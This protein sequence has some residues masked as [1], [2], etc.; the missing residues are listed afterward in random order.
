MDIPVSRLN[1]R[2]ALQLPTE[3]PLGLVFVVGEISEVVHAATT[4][5]QTEIE[6][7]EMSHRLRCRLT[8]RVAAEVEIKK[9]DWIRAGGHLT[10]DPYHADYVLLARDVELVS[11]GALESE[12]PEESQVDDTDNVS[13]AELTEKD[14]H[15]ILDD[16]AKRSH[17][18]ELAQG[19][20]PDWVQKIA[21]PEVKAEMGLTR[22]EMD[23]VLGKER[24]IEFL[25]SED[26]QDVPDAGSGSTD[27]ILAYL[28]EIMDEEEDVELEPEMV[29]E[30][31]MGEAGASVS[32]GSSKAYEVP[33]PIDVEAL[34]AQELLEDEEPTALPVAADQ[35]PKRQPRRY[36]PLTILLL[37]AALIFIT[38]VTV[39]VVSQLVQ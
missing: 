17:E 36:D 29:S 8:E 1:N 26:T 39:N 13:E 11:E 31:A 37:I 6:M 24:R 20:L 19:E 21:P 25:D 34:E 27:Q 32:E 4:G 7:T 14:A 33:E 12:E 22:S 23:L 18:A 15:P 2:L 28:A 30:L 9:G 5:G 35:K 10:F 3:L 16:I 38:A